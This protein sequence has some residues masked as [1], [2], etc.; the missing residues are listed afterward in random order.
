M[1]VYQGSN[2]TGGKLFV[3]INL[4]FTTKQYKSDNFGNLQK[5][6]IY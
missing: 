1:S 5:N 4:P 6:S 2:S 3:E